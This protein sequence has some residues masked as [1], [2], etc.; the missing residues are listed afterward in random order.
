M[1]HNT[2]VLFELKLKL[3]ILKHK[4]VKTFEI[5]IKH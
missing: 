2:N 4:H 1:R 5:K 3:I